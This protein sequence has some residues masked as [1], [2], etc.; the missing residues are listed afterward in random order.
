MNPIEHLSDLK[1]ERYRLDRLI[2]D[3][4]EK[5]IA[6]CRETKGRTYDVASG[7]VSLCRIAPKPRI[8]DPDAFARWVAEHRPDEIVPSVR[9]SYAEAFLRQLDLSD[10]GPV[11]ADG[12]TFDFVGVSA[13][14]EYL[15]VDLSDK[16][17]GKRS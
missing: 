15:R 9:S 11:T 12:E 1:A 7:T 2:R 8:V 17:K 13:G 16:A 5:A 14:S 3:A 10:E 4:E 6:Y